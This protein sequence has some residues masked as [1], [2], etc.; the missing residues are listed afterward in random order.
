MKKLILFI[1]LISILTLT[2]CFSVLRKTDKS[3]SGG[4]VYTTRIWSRFFHHAYVKTI[5]DDYDL[6]T[7][8]NTGFYT[9][10]KLAY[11]G[12]ITLYD[13]NFR[14]LHEIEENNAQYYVL[15]N[16]CI[17]GFDF[18]S[19]K[20]GDRETE[21]NDYYNEKRYS[22]SGRIYVE[23]TGG[24]TNMFSRPRKIIMWPRYK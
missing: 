10:A 11:T 9:D 4:V 5:P 13:R 15:D 14:K 18:Y 21:Y 17:F 24:L 22:Y 6:S 8:T 12:K 3:I 19:L 7:I 23:F 16:P 2:G 20:A 1:L